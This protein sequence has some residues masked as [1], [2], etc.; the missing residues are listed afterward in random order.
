MNNTTLVTIGW[1]GI[2]IA[3][4]G[5]VICA[6][7][8]G[9]VVLTPDGEVESADAD[10]FW[11]GSSLLQDSKQDRFVDLLDDQGFSEPRAYDW[12]G[13]VVYFA[14]G[15]STDSPRQV[16]AQL[17]EAFLRQGINDNAL[18]LPPD[19]EALGDES[20]D[21]AEKAYAV[22]AMQEFFSGG[23]MPVVD[24]GDQV[25]FTSVEVAAEGGNVET[26][27]EL[28][29]LQQALHERGYGNSALFKNFRYVEAFRPQNS[30]KT[31]KIA[32][33]GDENTN[34]MNFLPGAGGEVDHR[35]KEDVVP[36]C[37]GCDRVSRLSGLESEEAFEMASYNSPDT[38]GGVLDFYQRAL[39]VRGW[40]VSSGVDVVDNVAGLQMPYNPNATGGDMKVFR[41]GNHAVHVHAYRGDRGSTHVNVFRGK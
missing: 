16:A 1:N 9:F 3:V 28:L 26:L 2:K 15:Q 36:A 35:S 32:I 14:Q 13:N 5:A 27:D 10:I 29:M 37:P 41:R 17:Q 24:T 18:P 25:A 7:A 11:T 38:V 40:E 21:A 4:C 31:Q 20:A 12:N 33:F 6:L 19:P 39:L 23:M 34:F 8:M 22:L 30:R